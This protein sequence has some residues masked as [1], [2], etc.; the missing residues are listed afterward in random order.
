MTPKKEKADI[1][2]LIWN[3]IMNIFTDKPH[4]RSGCALHQKSLID[5][6]LFIDKSETDRH[7]VH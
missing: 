7:V 2:Q 3:R 4:N 1:N 5:L 6:H